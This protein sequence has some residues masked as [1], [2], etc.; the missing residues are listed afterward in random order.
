MNLLTIVGNAAA[1]DA[2]LEELFEDP[3]GTVEQYGFQLTNAEQEALL[4]FTQGPKSSDAKEYLRKLYICPRKPCLFAL[5]KPRRPDETAA[6]TE[7]PKV[8]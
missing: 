7:R 5:A 4:H 3:I 1:D 2:F 6:T 8:A